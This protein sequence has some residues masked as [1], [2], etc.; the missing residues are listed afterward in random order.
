M[1]QALYRKW[2]PMSFDDVVSQPHIT[3]TLKNQIISGKTAHA[4]L[5]TGSRGTGKT[6]CARIFAKAVNCLN[7][8]DG[9]PCLEC[10]ICKNADNGSLT[11]II[12]IDAAS[13][14]KVDDIRDLRDGVVYTP[15]MCKYKVYIIDEVH[16]LSPGAFNALLKIMEEPPP[17]VKFILA[18]TEVHKVPAT[19]VSRC[20]HFDFHRIR[21][22]DI[23]KRLEYIASHESFNLEHNAAEFIARLSDGGMRDALSLLDQ[24]AAYDDNITAEIVSQASGIAGRDYLFDI[25]ERISTHDSAGCIKII[26]KLYGMSKDLK[27]LVTELTAQMRNVMLIKSIDNNAELITCM[28]DEY[29]RLTDLANAM[30]LDEILS[31]ISTLQECS[32]SFALASNKRIELEMCMI[33]LCNSDSYSNSS[34]LNA[35]VYEDKIKVLSNR[36]TQLESALQKGSAVTSKITQNKQITPT[37]K[38]LIKLDPKGYVPINEWKKLISLIN[39]QSPAIGAFLD[40]SMASIEGNLF[41][42]VVA[43][44]FY[45]KR[46]AASDDKEILKKIVN[47][48]YGQNFEFKLY[49]SKSVDIE[50]KD[51]PIN[52]LLKRAKNAEIEVEIKR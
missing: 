6:T 36:I 18:T 22:E 33:K 13:N 20:Q 39:E 30:S 43:S 28:P 4:Y 31:T 23:V 34:R 41:K 24:C 52:E 51:N 49:S 19:I 5:F 11:D 46:F 17:H 9:E 7:P 48:Y 3:T 27:Q 50:D 47:D 32:E 38:K 1:Y 37:N 16:M 14:A 8:K 45:V 35:S 25:L 21:T 29:K 12:E 2:R 42:V 10:K 44:D 26:D 15:E 40:K